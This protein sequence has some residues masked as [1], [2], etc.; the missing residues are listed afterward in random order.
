[1][2]AASGP[3]RD[4]GELLER[5]VEERVRGPLQPPERETG[6]SRTPVSTASSFPFG[7]GVPTKVKMEEILRK[8]QKEA[9]GNKYKAIK[10]S[11]TLAVG[12]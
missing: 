2:E 8:L 1:M 10:E 9:S 12:K 4:G 6:L 7:R 11:S 3:R 5:S